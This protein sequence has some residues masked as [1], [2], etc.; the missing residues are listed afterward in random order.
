MAHGLSTTQ[1]WWLVSKLGD[2]GFPITNRAFAGMLNVA[3][4]MYYVKH[5]QEGIASED[6]Y[7]LVVQTWKTSME[8]L[9]VPAKRVD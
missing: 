7:H 5:V 4:E 2:D 9:Y 6:A 3:K 8:L 1:E